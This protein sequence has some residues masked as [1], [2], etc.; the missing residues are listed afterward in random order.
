MYD[1]GTM[2][3]KPKVSSQI[4]AEYHCEG[5]S[6]GEQTAKHNRRGTRQ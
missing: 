1:K 4:D 6:Y 5:L 2:R 3:A